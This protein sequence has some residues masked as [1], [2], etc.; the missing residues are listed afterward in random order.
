[1]TIKTGAIIHC[2]VSSPK[3]AIEGES[4]EVQSDICKR[5]VVERGWTLAHE[6]WLESFSGRKDRRPT[7]EE[8]LDF[9]DAHPRAATFY[10]FR[11]IDRF[12]RGGSFSYELMKRE[13]ARRGV[14]MIDSHGII[15]SPKNTLEH[16][17]FTYPWSV[18]S[19]SEI[20]EVVLATTASQEITTILTRLIGQEIRLTQEGYKVRRPTDGFV[21]KRVYIDGKKKIIDVPDPERDHFYVDMFN[22]RASGRYSDQQIVD[23][24]NAKGYRSRVFLRWDKEHQNVVG[25]RGGGP[26]SMKALQK[27]VRRPIYA[28]VKV[29]KWTHGKPVRAKYDGLVSIATFNQANRGKVFIKELD[30]GMLQLLYDHNPEHLVLQ[31]TRVNPL[32]PYKNVVLCPYCRNSFLGSAS[33]SKSGKHIPAYH[34]SRGHKRIGINKQTFEAN[35]D[36]MIKALR[37]KFEVLSHFEAVLINRYRERQGEIVQQASDV[38]ANVADLEAQKA[39]AVKSYIS[40]TVESL[41]QGIEAHIADLDKRIEL[42]RSVCNT[43]E[44]TKSDISSFVTRARYIMEHPAELLLKAETPSQQQAMYSLVFDGLPTYDEI[45]DGTP[46]LTWIFRG[47]SWSDA[48]E[49][50]SVRLKGLEWNT[51]EQTILRWKEL[52]QIGG[53]PAP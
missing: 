31:K 33:R 10:I 47:F 30:K 43:L 19:P 9:L 25:Q 6:P 8:I 52:C 13:L 26:L 1:M 20:T 45:V 29:E 14:E 11:S 34:C 48:D 5:I 24:L 28:G 22:M 12:T 42:T 44:V 16:T 49:S 41:R 36:R 27:I 23:Q 15:Q 4:L 39:A 18:R 46:K 2:R 51:I 35:V 17:G 37:F 7:F 40:A 38:S 50:L 3:Q 21:N 53:V 32:Y